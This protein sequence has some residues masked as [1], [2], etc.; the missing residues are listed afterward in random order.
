M[1]RQKGIS[2]KQ[3]TNFKK[4]GIKE[5]KTKKMEYKKNSKAEKNGAY[6]KR[7]KVY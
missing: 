6:K 3:Q 2:K 5:K 1:K 4:W 7:K